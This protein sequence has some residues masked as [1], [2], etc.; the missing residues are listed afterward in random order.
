M[1]AFI[2]A[3][4]NATRS[5]LLSVPIFFQLL[6]ESSTN[7]NEVLGV[8][9]W[10]ERRTRETLVRLM[11]D[12]AILPLARPEALPKEDDWRKVRKNGP[13]VVTM[14]PLIHRTDRQFL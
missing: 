5:R 9:K 2:Q 12:E 8:M 1:V 3:P 7:T 6:N 11:I 13:T 10:V 14:P 4:S